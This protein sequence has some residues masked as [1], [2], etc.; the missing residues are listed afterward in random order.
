MI[1][2]HFFRKFKISIGWLKLNKGFISQ[3]IILSN[4]LLKISNKNSKNNNKSIDKRF[5][6]TQK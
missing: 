5:M 4:L 3:L 2:S 1:W 6:I